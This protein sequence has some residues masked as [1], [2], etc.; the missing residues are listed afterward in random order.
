ML[1]TDAWLMFYF[2][3]KQVCLWQN[4]MFQFDDGSSYLIGWFRDYLWFSCSTFING[5]NAFGSND[6]SILTWFFLGAH[7]RR[8]LDLYLVQFGFLAAVS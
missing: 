5:Y 6:L 8:L 7:L 3:W 1:N 4:A 2:H